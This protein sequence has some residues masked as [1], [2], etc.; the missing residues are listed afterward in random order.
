MMRSFSVRDYV[1]V[2]IF[3]RRVKQSS[4]VINLRVSS[5]LSASLIRKPQNDLS[6]QHEALLEAQFSHNGFFTFSA[7]CNA[8]IE[9]GNFIQT[10]PHIS[11]TR[12][13][14]ISKET[15]FRIRVRTSQSFGDSKIR[16]TK[17]CSFITL[18]LHFARSFKPPYNPFPRFAN[19]SCRYQSNSRYI[20][21]KADIHN[22]TKHF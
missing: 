22:C 12:C 15:H 19:Q 3:S 18:T 8:S 10:F 1:D 14:P 20:P 16:R 21:V 13:H 7:T 6:S 2:V 4:D 11:S 5:E 9:N 17:R